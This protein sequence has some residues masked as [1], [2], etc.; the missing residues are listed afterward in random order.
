MQSRIKNLAGLLMILGSL[1]ITGAAHAIVA[2]DNY[3]VRPFLQLGG[4]GLID[5]LAVN[6]P[7]YA[8][9]N[10]TS[11][12]QS[13]VDLGDG[14]VKALAR[15]SGTDQFAQAGGSFGDRVTFDDAAGTTV[16]F[17]F[18]FDG[19]LK[20]SGP[21]INTGL[22]GFLSA[23]FYV[24]D[25]STGATWDNF[26]SSSLSGSAL[27]AKSI[28]TVFNANI[29][30][31]LDEVINDMLSGSLVIGAQ[32]T[33]DV[34]ASLSIGLTTNQNPVTL[35]GDFLHTGTFDIGTEQ[36]VSF[37]STSGVFLTGPT[38]PAPAPATVVLLAL[39]LTTLGYLRRKRPPDSP[40]LSKHRRRAFG[41]AFS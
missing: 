26:N 36:G 8:A 40:I 32:D 25:P 34:F 24:Y 38:A 31:T 14:T 11:A 1:G 18:A 19:T 9:Q 33:F 22:A 41:S 21:A 2:T 20:S 30:E 7:T 28:F 12:L 5:G 3:F 10:F 13:R 39:G 23:N 27:I 16:D 29:G 17:S 4:G 15:I 35:T 6:G 37:T